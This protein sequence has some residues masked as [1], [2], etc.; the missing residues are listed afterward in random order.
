MSARVPGATSA[1]DVPLDGPGE[2]VRANWS[3]GLIREPKPRL[4]LSGPPTGR[5]RQAQ[6][7]SPGE[8]AGEGAAHFFFGEGVEATVPF[9]EGEAAI[10]FGFSCFGFLGSRPPFGIEAPPVC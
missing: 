1:F 3:S 6:K 8:P 7:C 2:A 5:E 9:C 10:V 4:G